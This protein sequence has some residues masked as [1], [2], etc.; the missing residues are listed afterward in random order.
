MTNPWKCLL[1]GSTVSL[2][3]VAA[4]PRLARSAE[5]LP[6]GALD[7][8]LSGFARYLSARGERDDTQL[9]PEQATGLDFKNDTDV[10]VIARWMVAVRQLGFGLLRVWHWPIWGDRLSEVRLLGTARRA[11]D[12]LGSRPT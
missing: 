8:N 6:G 12:W 11:P 3:P 1:L 10:H 9:D 7:I 2:A 5:L 4:T